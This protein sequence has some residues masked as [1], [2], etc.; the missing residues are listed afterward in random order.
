M[1]VAPNVGVVCVG[2]P[3]VNGDPAAGAEN[4]EAPKVGAAVV[5]PPNN[6]EPPK[7]VEPNMMNVYWL[8]LSCTTTN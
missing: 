1:G 7:P 2:A 6:D 5:C 4:V 3:K 8:E